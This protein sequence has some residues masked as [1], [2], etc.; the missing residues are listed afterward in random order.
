M[1]NH[2]RTLLMNVDGNTLMD[3]VIAPEIVDPAYRADDL[4]TSLTRVRAVLFGADPDTSMLSYRCRQL[5]ALVHTTPMVE[6]VTAPDPRITYDFS[7]TSLLGPDAFRPVIRKNGDFTGD[8]VLFGDVVPP[9]VSGR[10]RH[11][12]EVSTTDV[13]QLEITQRTKPMRTVGT[14]F[15]AGDRIKLSDTGL[16]M[17][18]TSD[19]AGQWWYVT[20]YGRPSRDIGTM[21]EA[22]GSLGEPTLIEL[23]GITKS[24]PFRT[25]RD[26]FNYGRET[27]LRLAA[28]VLA[29]AYRTDALR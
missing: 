20:G 24:E 9:D 27:P 7:D 16:T 3:D 17:K 10:M 5:L 13:G 18:L 19:A 2:V 12:F 15:S 23:F 1:I 8:L 25:F 28:A 14:T 22:I 29:L 21:I 6:Y 4:P 11:M 26:V